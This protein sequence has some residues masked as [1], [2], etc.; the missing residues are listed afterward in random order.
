MLHALRS[1]I[2]EAS[3]PIDFA[4]A[5]PVPLPKAAVPAVG[6]FE[7]GISTKSL[8]TPRMEPGAIGSGVTIPGVI[9]AGETI[10]GANPTQTDAE[11][12]ISED[13]G[14]RSPEEYGTGEHALYHF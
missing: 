9:G 4:N 1:R 13:S 5:K 11:G 12:Q 3:Q 6:P 14:G 2:S 8:G 10:P 7:G